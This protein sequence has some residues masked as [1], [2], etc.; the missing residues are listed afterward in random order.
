MNAPHAAICPTCKGSG[1]KTRAWDLTLL[2]GKR[3]RQEQRCVACHGTGQVEPVRVCPSCGNWLDSCTCPRSK[4]IKLWKVDDMN[5]VNWV[6]GQQRWRVEFSRGGKTYY[7]GQ[8]PDKAMA[9]RCRMEADNTPTE[10]LPALRQKYAELKKAGVKVVEPEPEAY[11][12]HYDPAAIIRAID[13]IRDDVADDPESARQ[14]EG[15]RL[16]AM[17]DMPTSDAPVDDAVIEA[18]VPS[19]TDVLHQKLVAAR[20]ADERFQAIREQ[21]CAAERDAIDA[22]NEYARE[23]ASYGQTDTFYQS[24]LGFLHEEINRP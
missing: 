23:L 19:E 2:G 22:W 14:L 6:E 13:T 21:Y 9:I 11:P 8:Y 12:D 20:K 3:G 18:E 7:M 16:L 15:M 5:G 24:Y 10:Q 4:I 1:K 17:L